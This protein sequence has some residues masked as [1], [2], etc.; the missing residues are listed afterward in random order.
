MAAKCVLCALYFHTKQ[1]NFI[2]PKV[3]NNFFC[4]VFYNSIHLSYETFSK[5]LQQCTQ[6][7]PFISSLLEDWFWGP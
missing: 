6:T 4:L 2:F 5:V 7:Q 1:V 3:E